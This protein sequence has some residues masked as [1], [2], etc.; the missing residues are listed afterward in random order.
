MTLHQPSLLNV[1]EVAQRLGVSRAFVYDRTLGSGLLN[2][3]RLGR[4]VRYRPEDVDHLID[5]IAARE[6][7]V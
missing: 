5:R 6:V 1:E 3:I 7:T 4:S 2:P